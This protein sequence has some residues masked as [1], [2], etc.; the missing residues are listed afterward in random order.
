MVKQASR[1]IFKEMTK[2]A[3]DAGTFPVGQYGLNIFYCFNYIAPL[4]ADQDR[5]YTISITTAKSGDPE[6]YNFCF[7]RWGIILYTHP[8]CIW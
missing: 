7:S 5:S 2:S 4:H 1:Q 8:G 6:H 3:H